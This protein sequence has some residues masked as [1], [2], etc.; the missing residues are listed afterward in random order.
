MP[1]VI[2]IIRLKFEM[3]LPQQSIFNTLTSQINSQEAQRVAQE[4]P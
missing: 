1:A 2:V 4:K 3:S